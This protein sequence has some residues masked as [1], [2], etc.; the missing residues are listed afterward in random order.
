MV[1]EL[2]FPL[3]EW[4]SSSGARIHHLEDRIRRRIPASA[5]QA[6]IV[7]S[8]ISCDGDAY[9]GALYTYR[10]IKPAEV[11]LYGME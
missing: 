3:Y 2:S 4:I 10:I 5:R 11:A 1:R 8:R 6:S 7:S 9:Q